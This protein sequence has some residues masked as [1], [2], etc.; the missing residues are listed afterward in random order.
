MVLLIVLVEEGGGLPVAVDEIDVSVEV[1]GDVD[2]VTVVGWVMVVSAGML[3]VVE[4]VECDSAV[5]I[6][7]DV[8]IVVVIVL[9]DSS[10]VLE[11]G[12][13]RLVVGDV[14]KCGV[15]VDDGG[16]GDVVVVVERVES[17]L[18][19]LVGLGVDVVWVKGVFVVVDGVVVVV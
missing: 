4:M 15:G 2:V 16:I 6:V 11:D 1:E 14:G 10:I 7:S 12:G 17:V 13:I 8:Q 5:S 19:V 9:V 3:V 18:V